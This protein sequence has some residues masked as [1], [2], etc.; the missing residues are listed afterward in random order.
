MTSQNLHFKLPDSE[1][2]PVKKTETIAKDIHPL[3]MQTAPVLKIN[4]Q[5]FVFW[6]YGR[7]VGLFWMSNHIKFKNPQRMLVLSTNTNPQF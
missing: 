5:I 4:E 6:F 3:T 1:L 7:S 2:A